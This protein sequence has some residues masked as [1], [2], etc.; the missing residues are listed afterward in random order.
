MIVNCRIAYCQ[1]SGGMRG[2]RA[3]HAS[4][5]LDPVRANPF[6]GQGQAQAVYRHAVGE[7]RF[8]VNY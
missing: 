4:T 2:R 8:C 3:P 1:L 6:P 5:R 7:Y